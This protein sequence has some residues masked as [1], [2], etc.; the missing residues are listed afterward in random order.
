MQIKTT[1]TFLYYQGFAVSKTLFVSIALATVL[2][3]V[4]QIENILKI[5]Q[6]EEYFY[7]LD[8]QNM[9]ST[10]QFRRPKIVFFSRL[11]IL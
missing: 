1:L 3:Q 11:Y 2:L 10:F 8:Y 6:R 4:A 9:A 5:I 7:R